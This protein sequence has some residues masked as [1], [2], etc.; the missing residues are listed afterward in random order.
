MLKFRREA[1]SIL[2]RETLLALTEFTD[3][4]QM[5]MY[6]DLLF[7]VQEHRFEIPQIA[8]IIKE[9]GLVFEGFYLSANTLAQYGKMFPGD[10]RKTS[11]EN[12]HRFEQEH[13]STFM[14]MYVF[15][16]RKAE[17]C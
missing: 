6:R 11:L 15:W 2:P 8:S 1:P 5:N 17:G 4:F 10:S 7:H 13:P 14:Y 3:Y 12:W 16:C 9:L